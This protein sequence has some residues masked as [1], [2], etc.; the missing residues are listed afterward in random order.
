MALPGCSSRAMKS[1]SRFAV[2]PD[3]RQVSET[4][5]RQMKHAGEFGDEFFL[6]R[7]CW[8][9]TIEGMVVRVVQHGRDVP[10]DRGRMR[11]LEHLTE[12]PGME[13]RVVAAESFQQFTE[14]E[15]KRCLLPRIGDRRHRAPL[16][17]PRL[18]PGNG[19]IEAVTNHVSHGRPR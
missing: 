7:A 3:G 9:A 5:G 4:L 15:I 11:R 17:G 1:A 12:I 19:T 2:V 16:R 13:E 10:D 6:H 8:R 18:E 14:R